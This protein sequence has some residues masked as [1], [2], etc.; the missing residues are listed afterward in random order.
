MSKTMESTLEMGRQYERIA[1]W[2]ESVGGGV[3]ARRL[4]DILADPAAEST[5]TVAFCGLFSAGKS[6]LVSALSGTRLKTGANPTTADVEGVLM[7]LPGSTGQ[8]QLLDTPGIDST[9]ERHKEA[10]MN[11]L[12]QADC[13]VIVADYQHVEAEENLELLHAFVD[14]GK[15]LAFVVHQIDKHLESELPF[16]QFADSVY[17]VL[18]DYG[19]AEDTIFFT[20]V[21]QSPHNQL[22]ALR[23]WLVA[24][25][26]SEMA[27]GGV[28][29][30]RR[31]LVDVAK[32]GVAAYFDPLVQA[33]GEAVA[34]ACGSA[35]LSADEAVSWLDREAEKL[36]HLREQY[37]TGMQAARDQAQATRESWLRLIELAQIAPYDTTEKG[38]IYVESLRPEFKVGLFRSA[39]KTDAER[40]RRAEAFA[41][42]IAERVHNYLLT[43][44]ANQIASD[45][46]QA[47]IDPAT[48]ARL[49]DGAAA[50]HIDVDVDYVSRLVKPGALVS[51]QYPYQY[52]KD[53][54]A[55]VKRDALATAANLAEQFVAACLAKCEDEQATTRA[56]MELASDRCAAL[57]A[58]LDICAREQRALDL[59][60]AGEVPSV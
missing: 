45:V 7:S 28:E 10:T 12:Y 16:V 8:L 55:R 5:F 19:I 57:Q 40:L 13:V 37:D 3:Y 20:T 22:P 50:I 24:Q 54:V 52:V 48:S 33:A 32:E 36:R 58:Y 41:Q 14:E 47:G 38:R 30:V 60:A 2:L 18:A 42:D 46:R 49:A 56:D 59:V 23:S 9:D 6:S 29:N 21:G 43:P 35:P 44:L 53:V 26:E 39:Q 25:A 31:R 1:A 17:S 27:D 4:L 34:K 51:S 15:R 11:A